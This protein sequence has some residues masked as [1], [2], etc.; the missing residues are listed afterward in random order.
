M[1]YRR[2][3]YGWFLG[4]KVTF[5]SAEEE[6]SSFFCK[7]KRPTF[8]VKKLIHMRPEECHF[9]ITKGSRGYR[10]CV[11]F[12]LTVDPPADRRGFVGGGTPASS[13]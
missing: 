7:T 12:S 5:L 1:V 11:G 10:T 8:R 2:Q 3:L 13:L 4:L 6:M 9:S